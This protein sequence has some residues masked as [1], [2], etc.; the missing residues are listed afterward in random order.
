[1]SVFTVCKTCISLPNPPVFVRPEVHTPTKFAA[2][3]DVKLAADN[4]GNAPVSCAAGRPV[5]FAPSP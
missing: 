2:G 5:K 3:I 4:A 1:M